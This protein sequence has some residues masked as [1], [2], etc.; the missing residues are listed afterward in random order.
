MGIFNI[1]GISESRAARICGQ[2]V[3]KEK[4]QSLVVSPNYVKAKRMASDLSFFTRKN[5]YLMPSDDDS[6]T[7]YDAKNK[8]TLYRRL[9]VLRAIMEDENCIIVAPVFSAIKKLPPKKVF[10]KNKFTIKLED[11]INVDKIKK[12]LVYMGYERTNMIYAKGQFSLRGSI[13]DIFV[14]YFDNPVRIELF[15]TE[16][17]SI[18][19]FDVDTQRS[20]EKIKRV[21]ILPAELMVRDET[22]MQRAKSKFAANYKNSPVR[23]SELIDS[24]DNF[25]NIQQLE[26]YLDYFFEIP[27][28]VKDYMVGETVVFDD[29]TR[30]FEAIDTRTKEYEIDFKAL[31]AKGKVVK[32]DFDDFPKEYEVTQLYNSTNLYF[33]SPFQSAIKGIDHLDKLVDMSSMEPLMFGGNMEILEKEIKKYVDN[34]YKLSL[35]TSTEK[36]EN[37]LKEILQKLRLENKVQVYRGEL[38]S[39]MD[40]PKD[41]MA[42]ITDKEIFGASKTITKRKQKS[43]NKKA[44]KA[45]SE[46]KKGD[47]IVHEHHGVGKYLGIKQLEIQG[48]KKDYIHIKYA[49]DDKLYVPVNQMDM[50][51]KY[52]GSESK[53]P[54]INRLSGSDWAKTKA[55][56]KEAILEMAK[57]LI[58]LSA[59]RVANPGYQFGKD[60]VWQKQFE[61]AFP[62]EETGDQLRC[63]EEI[64]EDMEKPEA[65]DRL[66][67][68]DVGYGKTEVAARAMF[69]CAA[70]GKQVAM[71]VPTTILASQH[72]STLKERFKDFPFRVN[73]LSRFKTKAQQK[74]I[75]D[76]AAHGKIDILIGTHRLLSNDVK[77]KDL[78]LLVVDEEQRF[79]VGD[80]EK[81]KLL[82]ENVDVLTLSA[83]PIPRTLHM[84]LVGIRNMSVIEEPPQER[85]PVQTYVMEE[86][87][88]VI[89]E[90]IEREVGRGGQVF[91]IYNKVRGIKRIAKRIENLVPDKKVVIGHG[92]MNIHELENVMMD[93]I[94][95]DGDVLVATT[96]IESGI[97]IP[98]VNTEIIL[99][100][101]HFGLS[102]L[103]QLR[104]R[105]GRSTKLGYAYLMH[106]KEKTLTEVSEKRLRA[107]KEF[108]EFGSGFKISMRDLEIRGAGNILGTAQHGHMVSIGYELYC[109]LVDEA[110]AALNGEIIKDDKIDVTI[111]VKVPAYIPNDY[112][113]DEVIKLTVYKQIAEA[114]TKF[115]QKELIEELEDRFGNAPEEIYNLLDVS[116]IRTLA[117]ELNISKI[118][119]R[120]DEIRFDYERKGVRPLKIYKAIG[121]PVLEDIKSFLINMK[122]V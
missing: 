71:L 83:T 74:L 41:K 24:V 29:P 21:E 17:E 93:F 9:E 35:V 66:L 5:I 67:C 101:D 115:E 11:D 25:T 45:F 98:N 102:Q 87:D 8:D 120:G 118:S 105:V 76:E 19:I 47:Y 109:K 86:D 63:V 94:N 107:I 70:E 97:D 1:S 54:K 85:Y 12:K 44:I 68:G 34:E 113:S 82:K 84:S 30:I 31:L 22:S 78:G 62:Y 39:G 121:V 99:D 18:R 59:A 80:K 58:E 69:K 3:N 52:V 43:K 37:N 77:F 122:K 111:D 23:R 72:Y 116:R 92:Q 26:M 42:I 117:D 81:I 103:Y 48:I 14:P 38:S 73:L 36:R 49:G 27:E 4:G 6:F 110:V 28:T 112:I 60:T 51:Q 61:E 7:L 2:I 104:G 95:G 57:E 13:I 91:V 119:E 16:V 53:V 40:F 46:I 64:K 114:T 79:G 50:I 90:A 56:A 15:D 33:L 88:F 20:I 55:K 75:V 100:A 106:K 10:E 96:I 89:R 32:K 108:T 65:M